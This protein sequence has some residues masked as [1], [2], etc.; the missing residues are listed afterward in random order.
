[1][2]QLRIAALLQGMVDN[3]N[4][5]NIMIN[6]KKNCIFLNNFLMFFAYNNK[7]GKII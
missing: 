6:L 7:L 4:V 5:R 2:D 1:M 3:Y